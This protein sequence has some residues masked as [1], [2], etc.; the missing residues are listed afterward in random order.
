MFAEI[1]AIEQRGRKDHPPERAVV[2]N[3]GFAGRR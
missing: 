2:R 3:P 1:T